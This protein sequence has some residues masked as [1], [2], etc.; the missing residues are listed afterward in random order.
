MVPFIGG[1]DFEGL[2]AALP[3]GRGGADQ[4]PE[5]DDVGDAL[6]AE[7]VFE[8]GERSAVGR[9]TVQPGPELGR[10]LAG[11][12]ARTVVVRGGQAEGRR[13]RH[14]GRV[15]MRRSGLRRQ[16]LSDAEACAR[17]E[18]ERRRERGRTNK[19]SHFKKIG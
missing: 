18:E 3:P 1:S 13:R 8:R 7:A 12:E 10:A 14:F 6:G 16:V 9:R 11:R 2:G 17:R 4:L 5:R 15:P 19:L